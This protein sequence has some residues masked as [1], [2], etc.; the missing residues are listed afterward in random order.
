MSQQ[1]DQ[2]NLSPNSN[3]SNSQSTT[4]A[5][6][7]TTSDQFSNLQKSSQQ[8][9]QTTVQNQQSSP[10]Q[11]Q[12]SQTATTPQLQPA[13]SQP[14]QVAVTVAA[15][16]ATVPPKG[17]NTKKK[18]GGNKKAGGSRPKSV[19]AEKND[20]SILPQALSQMATDYY[21]QAVHLG[22][23]TPEG[24]RCYKNYLDTMQALEQHQ[25]NNQHASLS[26]VPP[27]NQITSP[28]TTPSPNQMS[29]MIPTTMTSVPS[30]LSSQPQT[31]HNHQNSPQMVA[32]PQQHMV[33]RGPQVEYNNLNYQQLTASRVTNSTSGSSQATYNT[34]RP[35]LRP[36]MMPPVPDSS[37]RMMINTHGH[38]GVTGSPTAQPIQSPI[39]P[40]S[41]LANNITEGSMI[42]VQQQQAM[43]QML[44]SPR[45]QQQTQSP[46]S[47]LPPQSPRSHQVQS[48][49]QSPRSHQLQPLSQSPQLQHPSQSPQSQPPH[50]NSHVINS[51]MEIDT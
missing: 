5:N 28:A 16:P 48:L 20:D 26:F 12:S 35:Y 36:S 8:T 4:N 21:N 43:H 33:G 46:G 31:M 32:R 22:Q 3:M 13:T 27:V 7:N 38:S 6:N 9:Q 51:S 47:Q 25:R 10:Q 44:Q 29:R 17:G 23:D 41:P 39:I 42:T 30:P 45:L 14:S 2:Q 24:Q 18:S 1:N 50:I 49:P 15:R 40:S 11:S 19:T 34:T 37:S